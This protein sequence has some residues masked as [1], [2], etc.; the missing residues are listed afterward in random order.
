MFKAAVIFQLLA[1]LAYC[2]APSTVDCPSGSL[3]RE[4][5]NI[6]SSEASW[7]TKRDAI[8]QAN[9]VDFLANRA[10]LNESEYSSFLN[11]SDNMKL[12]MA[13]SG[14]GFRAMLTGAGQLAALDSRTNGANES[15]LGGLLDSATY[16]S[17][18][19]GGSWL[20][21][22][23]AM[24]NWTSV[25]SII[26]NDVSLWELDNVLYNMGSSY[27][28]Y[29]YFLQW[30]SDIKTKK[31]AGFPVTFLDIWGRIISDALFPASED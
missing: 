21:G 11:D 3:L 5:T 26:D 25:Q 6:S 1:Q 23:L 10:K 9:L 30:M 4:A 2:Y 16:I 14:G 15:G 24:N 8:T 7:L 17:G 20:V 12:S 13:F 29:S 27:A 31:Q 28:I 18:L 22:S 19:S